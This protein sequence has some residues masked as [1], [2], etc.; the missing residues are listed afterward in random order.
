M[1]QCTEQDTDLLEGCLAE[2]LSRIF[3]RSQVLHSQA[4]MVQ[5]TDPSS[6][7]A[8][9]QNQIVQVTLNF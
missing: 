7:G 6:S 8:L 2:F 4:R 1:L 3:I 9:T 5:N